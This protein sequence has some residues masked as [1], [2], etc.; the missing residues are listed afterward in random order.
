M[1]AH[2]DYWLAMSHG[3]RIVELDRAESLRLLAAKKVGRLAM[4]H[5]GAPMIIPMNFTLTDERVIFR[6]L[7][8]GLAAH[9]VGHP[10]AFEVDDIDDFLEAGWSVVVGGTARLLSEEELSELRGGGPD[11]WAE[12]PRTLYVEVPIE[13]LS[14]RQLVPR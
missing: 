1:S 7:A 11:P 10:V 5:D 14:G 3:A 13:H 9:A 8:H 6:T 4:V 12:G 2:E